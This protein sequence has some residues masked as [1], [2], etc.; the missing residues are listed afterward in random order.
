M[1]DPPG[2]NVVLNDGEAKVTPFTMTVPR[3]QDLQLHFSKPGY[4][5]VN[6]SDSSQVEPAIIVDI[7]PFMIPWA[8]DASEGAGYAHQQTT[9][10]AHLDPLPGSAPQSTSATP[11]QAVVIEKAETSK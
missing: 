1:S 8:I 10:V 6:L 9:L 11:P 4:Q 5:P 7:F 2:A 3:N